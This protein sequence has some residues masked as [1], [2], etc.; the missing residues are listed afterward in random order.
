MF[1]FEQLFSFYI[2]KALEAHTDEKDPLYSSH[3]YFLR[4]IVNVMEINT[5]GDRITVVE[6]R[7]R[8]NDWKIQRP[9]GDGFLSNVFHY[10]HRLLFLGLMMIIEPDADARFSGFLLLRALAHI[11]VG[12]TLVNEIDKYKFAFESSM[13]LW[14]RKNGGHISRLFA[15]HFPSIGGA[16]FRDA[17]KYTETSD[18]REWITTFL[19]PWAREIH[20]HCANKAKMDEQYLRYYRRPQSR[21]PSIHDI[22]D[23]MAHKED[24]D[25]DEDISAADDTR[26]KKEPEESITD[27]EEEEEN[28]ASAKNETK[29]PSIIT[30]VTMTATGNS[31][32]PAPLPGG[33][34][35]VLIK[36]SS[37]NMSEAEARLDEDDEDE[38]WVE[39]SV[40]SSQT[41]TADMSA[42]APRSPSANSR[43][44][45]KTMPS[46]LGRS[47][48]GYDVYSMPNKQKV[49]MQIQQP[50]SPKINK[51]KKKTEQLLQVFDPEKYKLKGHETLLLLSN[52]FHI[53]TT[54]TDQF[55]TSLLKVWKELANAFS[56]ENL[57]AI[58]DFL[59]ETVESYMAQAQK[60]Q[61][62]LYTQIMPACKNIIFA[63]YEGPSE[64]NRTNGKYSGSVTKQPL[65]LTRKLITWYIV[66]SLLRVLTIGINE[67]SKSNLKIRH[68]SG[69]ILTRYEERIEEEEKAQGT[70]NESNN[71]HRLDYGYEAHIDGGSED[72]LFSSRRDRSATKTQQASAS[73][74]TGIMAAT[75][76][77]GIGGVSVASANANANASAGGNAHTVGLTVDSKKTAMSR[78]QIERKAD[79]A[80]SLLVDIIGVDSGPIERDYPVLV[81]YASI[82]ISSSSNPRQLHHLL[83]RIM[84]TLCLPKDFDMLQNEQISYEEASVAAALKA[85]ELQLM[86]DD[87][88]GVGGAVVRQQFT[89]DRVGTVVM[90]GGVF[91]DKYCQVLKP[92]LKAKDRIGY[93]ALRWAV[94]S[95]NQDIAQRAFHVY[96]QLLNPLNHAAVKV[97][98][99]TLVGSIDQWENA[100][101]YQKTRQSVPKEFHECM[102]ILDTLLKM[103]H[104]LKQQQQLHEHPA[105]FWAGIALLRANVKNDTESELFDRGLELVGMNLDQAQNPQYFVEMEDWES[106]EE[107]STNE[108]DN[109][110]KMSK[111]TIKAP[112]ETKALKPD[113]TSNKKPTQIQNETEEKV[114]QVS[115]VDNQ[116]SLKPDPNNLPQ[117]NLA[118][119]SGT[120][121][122]NDG[123]EHDIT[124]PQYIAPIEDMYNNEDIRDRDV[125]MEMEMQMEAAERD[126]LPEK[127]WNYCEEWTPRFEGVQQYFLFLLLLFFLQ[128]ETKINFTLKK[129]KTK[130]FLR[131]Q[132]EEVCFKMIKDALVTKMDNIMDRTNLRPLLAL[133][134]ILPYICYH[135][136][137][138]PE[139]L[140]DL[141]RLFRRLAETLGVVNKKLSNKFRDYVKG[142]AI[143]ED[144]FLRDMCPLIVEHFFDSYAKVAANY[145]EGLLESPGMEHYHATIFKICRYFLEQGPNFLLCFEKIIAKAHK[146]VSGGKISRDVSDTA[147]ELVRTAI[148]HVKSNKEQDSPDDF[149]DVSPF[150]EAGLKLSIICVEKQTIKNPF[151]K[152]ALLSTQTSQPTSLANH[153]PMPNYGG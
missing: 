20:L 80:A 114:P 52:L 119:K 113:S 77:I 141:P 36:S 103:A 9:I 50:K 30:T 72:A 14:V 16:L 92:E 48:T 117:T 61:I 51:K 123:S 45:P 115:T 75:A 32:V 11:V 4:A 28:E 73:S 152:H 88:V 153:G 95:T 66:R 53:T 1:Q 22:E 129:T 150:P 60:Q 44:N 69:E 57:F 145:F 91:I 118:L 126:G 70:H 23:K 17:I 26:E 135:S 125:E 78:G 2:E 106:R 74:S 127:F 99:L 34:N 76:A 35:M 94:L 46:P 71:E 40:D 116:A 13:S 109:K 65:A 29:N 42:V 64:P 121:F 134:A 98:L 82:F 21:S 139:K 54:A 39:N 140:T 18:R 130:G 27:G 56:Y 24:G 144:A 33:S 8:A 96:R 142:F 55:Q 132:H 128:Y 101:K 143:E 108:N 38:A 25:D 59:I 5:S 100:S 124:E 85:R 15:K 10:A 37:S 120:S 19:K 58:L 104:A 84:S 43:N 86:W 148:E 62:N 137:Y 136:R 112:G 79:L 146:A 97:V 133:I 122:T 93:E 110:E 138:S 90:D 3:P 6:S 83:V 68:R 12:K 81:L 111:V 89:V 7:Y 149:I 63:I 41:N 67:Y 31:S 151:F 105:L 102:R 147:T 131:P 47:I 49:T 87:D 107:D